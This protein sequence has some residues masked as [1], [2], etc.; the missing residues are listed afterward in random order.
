MSRQEQASQ[1]G[2]HRLMLI[3]RCEQ[4]L[5]TFVFSLASNRMDLS[6]HCK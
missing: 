3:A 1:G 2:Q 5:A 6:M 4:M